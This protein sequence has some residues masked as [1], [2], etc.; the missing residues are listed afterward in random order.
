MEGLLQHSALAS[1]KS[2]EVLFRNRMQEVVAKA[3]DISEERDKAKLFK[4]RN[5]I[6]MKSCSA[7]TMR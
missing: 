6:L 2:Q 3:G 4:H 5:D 1:K 7:R